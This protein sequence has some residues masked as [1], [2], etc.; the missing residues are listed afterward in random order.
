M[1]L[2]TLQ[3]IINHQKM[4][5]I[6]TSMMLRHRAI[7]T[8][9]TMAT[10]DS[11]NDDPV[12]AA[13]AQRVSKCL[14]KFLPPSTA[15][16]YRVRERMFLKPPAGAK[17]IRGGGGEREDVSEAGGRGKNSKRGG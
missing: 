11:D 12:E 5:L 8:T 10:K 2:S 14:H 1:L 16:P 3:V 9:T 15:P 13:M 4:N 7:V 6:T 17:P